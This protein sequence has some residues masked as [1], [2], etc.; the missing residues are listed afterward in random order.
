MVSYRLIPFFI[1]ESIQFILISLFYELKRKSQFFHF[2]KQFFGFLFL[3]LDNGYNEFYSGKSKLHCIKYE[4]G[5]HIN[6]G[7]FISVNGPFPGSYHDLTIFKD[8][9]EVFLQENGEMALGDKAYK[10]PHCYYPWNQNQIELLYK[11][12]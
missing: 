4:F 2:L 6:T 11:L 12:I 8:K 3:K 1:L 9:L 10:S 5:V 7:N